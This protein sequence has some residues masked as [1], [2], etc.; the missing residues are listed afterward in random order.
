MPQFVD[1]TGAERLLLRRP[2]P[3][4]P[5][6][7]PPAESCQGRPAGCLI[8]MH[9]NID[10]SA[11]HEDDLAESLAANEG[12]ARGN[13]THQLAD[14]ARTRCGPQRAL[15]GPN[16]QAA[17]PPACTACHMFNHTNGSSADALD[18]QLSGFLSHVICSLAWLQVCCHF[19]YL[20]CLRV[21]VHGP[22]A[23]GVGVEY[24]L[25]FRRSPRR[26]NAQPEVAP[27]PQQRNVAWVFC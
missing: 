17:W 9:I 27:L 3:V 26:I 23:N 15:G 4:P 20:Y 18:K 7:P 1:V 8:F 5:R 10:M 14:S 13:A 22:A 6:S 12:R 2:D 19:L 24:F 16:A 21:H 25:P 11:S